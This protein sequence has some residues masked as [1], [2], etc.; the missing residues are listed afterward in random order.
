MTN[1]DIV[2]V[3]KD[4]IIGIKHHNMNKGGEDTADHKRIDQNMCPKDHIV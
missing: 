1:T 3:I 4:G 2:N